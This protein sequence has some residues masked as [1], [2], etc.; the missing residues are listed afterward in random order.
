LLYVFKKNINIKKVILNKK[1]NSQQKK[2]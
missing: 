2:K 1:K